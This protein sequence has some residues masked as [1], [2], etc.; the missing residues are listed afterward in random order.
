MTSKAE[1]T[2]QFIIEKT[3]P[4]FN[5][6]G[7]AGTSLNDMIT[8][9]GLTKGSIYGNFANKD[10]VAIAAFDYNFRLVIAYIKSQMDKHPL[11]IDKL[12]VYPATYRNYYKLP[13]LSQGCPV[14]NTSTE[15][16]DTHPDLKEKAN[17]AI[18]YWRNAVE[19]QLK[20]GIKSG[21]I[22]AATNIV[23]VCGVITALIQGAVLHAKTSGKM[24][25]LN[26][27]MDYLENFIKNLKA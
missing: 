11:Y 18:G 8:A 7:Y 2:K 9:T 16:D 22:N 27:S 3:A 19:K 13:F 12:L 6:K 20:A 15:A 4:I 14:A 5:T 25:Y 23:E 24:T 26:A 21:E 1:R 10:D 17:A